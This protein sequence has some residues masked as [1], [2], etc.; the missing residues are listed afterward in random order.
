MQLL[1]KRQSLSRELLLKI[2]NIKLYKKNFL[3]EETH[4][5]TKQ[6]IN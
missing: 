3:K 6:L 5:Q 2:Y 4:G 1:Q